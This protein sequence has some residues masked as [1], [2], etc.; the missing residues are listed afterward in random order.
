MDGAKL[1]SEPLD[2]LTITPAGRGAHV[3]AH[4]TARVVG[5]GS[6]ATAVKL[7]V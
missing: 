1:V 3:N 4:E 2:D 7:D 5:Q 6:I